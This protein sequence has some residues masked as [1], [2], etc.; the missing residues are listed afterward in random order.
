MVILMMI[1]NTHIMLLLLVQDFE[2]L[3]SSHSSYTLL[4]LLPEEGMASL[5]YYRDYHYC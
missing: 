5:D 1:S 2:V 3:T 4:I